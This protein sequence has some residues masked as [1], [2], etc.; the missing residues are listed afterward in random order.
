MFDATYLTHTR[1]TRYVK[2][3]LKVKSNTELAK[4]SIRFSLPGL[5]EKIDEQV[6]N[7]IFTHSLSGFSNYAKSHFIS[8]YNPLCDI[9]NCY[10]CQK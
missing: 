1:A 2:E 3:P 4:A 8:L 6:I 7:K 10:V 5:I 9:K